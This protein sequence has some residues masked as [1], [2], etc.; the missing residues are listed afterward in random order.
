MDSSQS[1]WETRLGKEQKLGES[2]DTESQTCCRAMLGRGGAPC[3][4][5]VFFSPTL[6]FLRQ[7]QEKG[8]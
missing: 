2:W 5:W 7:A 6:V 4:S 1:G 3:G 8:I